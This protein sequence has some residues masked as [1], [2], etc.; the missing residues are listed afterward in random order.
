M[1]CQVKRGMEQV[2][3]Y[4]RKNQL[5]YYFDWQLHIDWQLQEPFEPSHA[6]MAGLNLNKGQATDQLAA[7]LRRAFSGIVAG[8]VK[9]LWH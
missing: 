8:N 4:R 5:A 6:N 9:G 3:R 7:E 1:A 2:H